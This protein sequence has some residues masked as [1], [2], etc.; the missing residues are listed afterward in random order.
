MVKAALFLGPEQLEIREFPKPLIS[1]DCA[2]LKVTHCG[3]CGTDLHIYSGHLSVP[4]PTILGH[5]F[6]GIL[7]EMGPDFPRKDMLGNGLKEGDAITI[8]T[9]LACG[10]CY[11]CKLGHPNLCMDVRPM[12]FKYQGG[13][14]QY[15]IIPE[16]ALK[17]GHAI[18][19][20]EGVKPQHAA[21]AEPLSCAV[22]SAEN[23]SI[24]PNDTVVVV[25]AGPMGIMN[26]C[27]A[28]G[29]GAKKIILAET[30][31]ARLKS[32]ETF[33]FDSYINPLKD[34]LTK[35]VLAET[36]GIGADIV[37]VAA[38]A[39]APQQQAVEFVRKRGSVCLFASLPLGKNMLSVDSRIIHYNEIK[40]VGTSDSTPSQ[41][42]SCRC[43]TTPR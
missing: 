25:G 35:A 38:P 27:I 20:P 21:L 28:K 11:Y 22:N 10:E 4:I 42:T 12:G 7:E 23:C 34:D 33:G 17:N 24:Q 3:V 1:K 5:E 16:R 32:T 37:I 29:L 26:A 19:V 30:N 39:A 41:V 14:A 40:I 31:E 6:S 2:L 18:K 13:M 15:T 8:G 9:S 43:L 36:N